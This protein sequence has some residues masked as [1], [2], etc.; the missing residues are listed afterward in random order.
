MKRVRKRT[1][2]IMVQNTVVSRAVENEP[3]AIRIPTW[4]LEISER[5]QKKCGAENLSE[6][7]RGLML[8]H[9]K[10]LGIDPPQERH[11]EWPDWVKKTKHEVD[12]A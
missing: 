4:L 3:K 10:R 12:E 6:Y 11:E 5:A 7:I 2:E 8:L 1:K 9:A